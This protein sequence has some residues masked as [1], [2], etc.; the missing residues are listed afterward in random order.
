[1]TIPREA[2]SD[3]APSRKAK[4][5][6]D[7]E[8][9]L[10]EGDDN[11]DDLVISKEFLELKR[12][13]REE[14]LGLLLRKAFT[15]REIKSRVGEISDEPIRFD[16][17]NDERAT[18]FERKLAESRERLAELIK[19]VVTTNEA[20]RTK[21]DHKLVNPNF[22]I[23]VGRLLEKKLA[24]RDRRPYVVADGYRR[25]FERPSKVYRVNES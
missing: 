12:L 8:R 17:T 7:K 9:K 4:S 15:D 25:L 20:V 13:L 24:R 11:D 2:N 10:A 16:D 21:Q 22:G 23:A 1:M 6:D 18:T 5:K 3:S 19:I 14:Q